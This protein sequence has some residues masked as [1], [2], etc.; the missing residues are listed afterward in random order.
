M[1]MLIREMS[2]Q[3]RH[4]FG[5]SIDIAHEL[6]N[7]LSEALR[8]NDYAMYLIDI[9]QPQRA[10]LSLEQALKLINE[11]KNPLHYALFIDHMGLAY[12]ALE[13]GEKALEQHILA[14]IYLSKIDAPDEMLLNQLHLT[15]V[16]LD[17][18]QISEAS[19]D[20]PKLTSDRIDIQIQYHLTMARL[21]LLQG[22]VEEAKTALSKAISQAKSGYRQ[23]LLAKAL[24][25][26]SQIQ[27][28]DNDNDRAVE[29]WESAETL[30]KLLQM[31]TPNPNWLHVSSN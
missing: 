5:E 8:R 19:D 10:V 29:T 31:P 9:G 3:L 26:Q 24:V 2:Y 6:N 11:E 20:I 21:E 18:T 4:F 25:L 30:L 28:A 13:Q 14:Q 7:Q 15:E 16:Y 27:V 17:L 1:R 12:R 22:N 23:R